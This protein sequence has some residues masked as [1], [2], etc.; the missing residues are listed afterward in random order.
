MGN[1]NYFTAGGWLFDCD[2]LFI[3][4]EIIISNHGTREIEGEEQRH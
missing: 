3:H 1:V 4:V 2:D